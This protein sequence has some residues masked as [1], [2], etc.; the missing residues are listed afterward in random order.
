MYS[1]HKHNT[2]ANRIRGWPHKITGVDPIAPNGVAAPW[3]IELDSRL[4]A[5]T[6][7]LDLQL[8]SRP[9]LNPLFALAVRHRPFVHL[10]Q[11]VIEN[12]QKSFILFIKI[13]PEEVILR[14]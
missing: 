5:K 6:L 9:I 14:S 2:A 10:S 3:L 1:K 4:L 7:W 13:V 12:I 11:H 8:L